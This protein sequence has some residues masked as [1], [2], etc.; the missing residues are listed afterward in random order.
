MGTKVP[1][2]V[3]DSTL[4]VE[5]PVMVCELRLALTE[6]VLGTP[7]PLT[8]RRTSFCDDKLSTHNRTSADQRQITTTQLHA[9]ASD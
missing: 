2:T 6:V 7:V 5:F 8:D 9:Q 3:V 4:V 1:V